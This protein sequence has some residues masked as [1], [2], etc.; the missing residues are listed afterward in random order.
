MEEKKALPLVILV[1][2][3]KLS[4]LQ[5]LLQWTTTKCLC[6]YRY[7][8]LH[9]NPTKASHKWAPFFFHILLSVFYHQ[10][11]TQWDRDWEWKCAKLWSIICSSWCELSF[12]AGLCPRAPIIRK[13]RDRP[14]EFS[15]FCEIVDAHNFYIWC[16][17]HDRSF[18][19]GERNIS[20]G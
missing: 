3:L 6:P 14:W 13:C 12:H 17:F 4:T 18:F 10:A 15:T 7:Y 2:F 20:K 11:Q 5:G 9:K 1:Q 16:C 19:L 8:I